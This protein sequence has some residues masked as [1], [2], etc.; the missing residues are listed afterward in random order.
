MRGIA[1]GSGIAYEKILVLN[2]FAD[3]ILGSARFCSAV[4]VRGKDG[5]LVGRNLDWINHSV[6]H[7][8]GIVF[9]LEPSGERRV[10]S[11][12]WPGMVGVV[13]GMNDR[14]VVITMNMA[15]ANDVEPNAVPALLRIRDA[16]DH[17]ARAEDAIDAATSS[18]RTMAM[19][20]MVA[21]RARIRAR[22]FRP[23]VCAAPNGARLRRD[24][25]R[26]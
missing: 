26:V 24:D 2:T 20:W 23:P 7:R 15:F 13:T 16:L 5:L 21:D 1:D 4:A 18:P 10:M 22:A 12:G 14:G 19:N 3:S 17:A 6:A 25:K 8:A 9:I 11:I